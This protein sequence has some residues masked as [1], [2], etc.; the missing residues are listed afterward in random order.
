[1]VHLIRDEVRLKSV[2]SRFTLAQLQQLLADDGQPAG[3][4][5]AGRSP[6]K[7]GAAIEVERTINAC[8]LL[9]LAGR[10]HPVGYHL[11]GRRV[12]ARLDHGVL[13]LLDTDRA[14]LRS[15]PNPLT[16]TERARIRDAR[17]AGPAPAP[18]TVLLRVDRRVSCR[19]SISIARQK[20]QVGIGHA[21]RT[22]TVEEAD[23]TFRIYDG[24]QLLTEV[25]RTATRPIAR[26]KARKPE[27]PRRS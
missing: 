11:A 2:P 8:G 27:P 15:L 23:T 6:V 13:H 26:F 9:A 14:A 7:P 3:P 20:I 17:P 4:P 19:G 16:A 5:P 10:Q 1:V 12:T 18:A 22:L 21:G 24:D 25:L